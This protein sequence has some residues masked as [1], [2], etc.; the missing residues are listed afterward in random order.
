MAAGLPGRVRVMA[1]PGPRRV[2]GFLRMIIDM[3]LGGRS[4]SVSPE[5][6]HACRVVPATDGVQAV[7]L[8]G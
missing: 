7:I 2:W 1:I 6:E 3:P 5:G 4:F 8:I